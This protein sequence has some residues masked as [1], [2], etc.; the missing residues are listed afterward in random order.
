MTASFDA[1]LVLDANADVGEGP[2]WDAAAGRLIWVDITASRVHELHPDGL[3]RSWNVGEHVGAAVPRAS[4]GLVLATRAGFAVLAPDGCVTPIAPVEADVPGNRMN[5][6]KCDPQ[7]R[8][9]AGTMPYKD[10]PGAGSLY[11]LDK[12]HRVQRVLPGLGLANGLG[13]SPDGKT[14]YFIDSTTQS[15]DAYDF[16]PGDGALSGCRQ[17]AA[18]DP[19]DGMPDGMTVDD[20]GC[21]WVALWGGGC[22]RR[23]RP[24]GTVAAIVHL[25]AS[26]VTS[27]AFG[28]PDRGDLYITSAAHRL[29]EQ[30]RAAE[31]HAGGL[32]W[33]RPGVTGPPAVPYAG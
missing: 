15:V 1:E 30:Q 16:D 25:P 2:A 9:W 27:C 33:C 18:I 17:V 13:W 4:G 7:G 12:D 26:Q 5:D 11:R 6:G 32:F 31:P 22:V 19:A 8:F 21:L 14:F 29:S 23:Y 24:D 3:A 28:G 10:T 20:E